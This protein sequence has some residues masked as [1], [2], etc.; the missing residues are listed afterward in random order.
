MSKRTPR[1]HHSRFSPGTAHGRTTSSRVRWE[2]VARLPRWVSPEC[3]SSRSCCHS[4]Y[5]MALGA[6]REAKNK[7]VHEQRSEESRSFRP[8][9][10]FILSVAEGLG[11]TGRVIFEMGFNRLLKKA[12]SCFD[13]LSTNGKSPT[14]SSLPPFALSLSKGERGFFSTLLEKDRVRGR[15]EKGANGLK[16]GLI[17]EPAP[18]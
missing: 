17:D 6:I 18:P 14:T 10:E 11:V 8:F 3:H 7:F 16:L 4:E 1:S 9:A 13:R 15:K 12:F 5:P 2:E